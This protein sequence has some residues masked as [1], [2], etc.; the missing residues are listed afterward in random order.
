MR[1]LFA[2][3]AL[4]AVGTTAWSQPVIEPG[5]PK[6]THD[7]FLSYAAMA[8]VAELRCENVMV[9]PGYVQGFLDATGLLDLQVAL[10]PDFSRF[11][12]ESEKETEAFCKVVLMSF[13]SAPDTRPRIAPL[14]IKKIPQ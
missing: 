2:F 10:H 13:Y 3:T 8:A 14:L 7:E 4:L 6:L 5:K 11:M 1:I 9:S 12:A